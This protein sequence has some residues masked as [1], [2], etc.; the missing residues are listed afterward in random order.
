[1]PMVSMNNKIKVY[2]AL[3]DDEGK[4]QTDEWDRP[5]YGD[6]FSLRC[7]MH[8][9]TKLVRAQT[10]QGGVHGINAQEVVSTAQIYCDKL[11]PIEE[12]D[13]IEFVNE[14]GR[15]RTYTP[16]SIEIRRWVNGKP[17]LTVINV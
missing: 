1:M 9:T 14:R 5:V 16:I 2:P 12:G 3:L 7:R 17:L 13:R 6:P 4:P 8:E 15:I 11:A 10:N